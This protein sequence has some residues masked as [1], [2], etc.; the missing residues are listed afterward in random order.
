MLISSWSELI[1]NRICVTLR[2]HWWASLTPRVSHCFIPSFSRF[3][4][5]TKTLLQLSLSLGSFIWTIGFSI[6]TLCL[7]SCPLR[8]VCAVWGGFSWKQT[9]ANF[10]DVHLR[11]AVEPLVE[12]EAFCWLG[13]M[14]CSGYTCSVHRLC[15]VLSFS[16]SVWFKNKK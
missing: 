14:S 5:T 16:I 11:C 1:A 2:K 8:L 6:L 9:C 15:S 12:L 7:T 3:Q 10:S 13:V 4:I